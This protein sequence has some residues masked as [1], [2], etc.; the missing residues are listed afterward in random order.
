[1][2]IGKPSASLATKLEEVEKARVAEQVA[3]LGPDGLKAAEKELQEAKAEHD[4]PIPTD[5]LTSFPIP[6]VKSISWIPVQSIQEPGK[7]RNP[8]RSS[9]NSEL[10]KH[11]NADGSTPPFF[12]QYDHV[13]V[14]LWD[15]THRILSHLD[16]SRTSSQS[17]HFSLWPTSLTD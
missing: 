4:L 13:E 17:M 12:V 10:S 1:M 5:V 3:K 6:S 14:S 16:N 15:S 8:A 11:V 2:V 7:G 9:T